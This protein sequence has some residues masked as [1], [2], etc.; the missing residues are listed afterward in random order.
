MYCFNARKTGDSMK[1]Q[2]KSYNHYI[3]GNR[4]SNFDL[5]C[6]YSIKC[7]KC[8]VIS[9]NCIFQSLFTHRNMPFDNREFI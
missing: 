5:P 4:Y 2:K 3:C 7:N 8:T 9:P 6:P 1:Y